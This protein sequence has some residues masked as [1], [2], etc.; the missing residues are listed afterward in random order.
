M[1]TIH[2]VEICK[3]LLRNQ[4]ELVGHFGYCISWNGERL[5]YDSLEAFDNALLFS[6]KSWQDQGVLDTDMNP[7][8]AFQLLITNEA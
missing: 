4:R 6:L 1:L 8:E 7:E 5:E 2:Y 3:A